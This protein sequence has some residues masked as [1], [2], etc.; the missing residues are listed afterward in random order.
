M[1]LLFPFLPWLRVDSCQ[2]AY[3]A[4]VWVKAI[5]TCR[6]QHKH[7]IILRLDLEQFHII[8]VT[9]MYGNKSCFGCFLM[10]SKT[11]GGF[12]LTQIVNAANCH[13]INYFYVQY[14]H[15]RRELYISIH[16]FDQHAFMHCCNLLKVLKR[17]FK[18]GPVA[19]FARWHTTATLIIS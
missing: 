3:Y 10:T 14:S 9:T 11:T 1:H 4:R 13:L 6:L 12:G 5:I 2:A 17:L 19:D 8:Y 15:H 18:S 7:G 16:A